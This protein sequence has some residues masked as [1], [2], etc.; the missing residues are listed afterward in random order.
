MLGSWR[1]LFKEGEEE[2]GREGERRV[3]AFGQGKSETKNECSWGL[4]NAWAFLRKLEFF[5]KK[6]KCDRK[7]AR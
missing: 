3:L 7:P 2:E 5:P 6:K 1:L 4:P